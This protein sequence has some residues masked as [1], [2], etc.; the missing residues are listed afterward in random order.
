[1][2]CTVPKPRP[3][4]ALGSPPTRG[5][6]RPVLFALP[7]IPREVDGDREGGHVSLRSLSSD[8]RPGCPLPEIPV[9]TAPP[10]PLPLRTCA[11]GPARFRPGFARGGFVP[12]GIFLAIVASVKSYEH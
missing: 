6:S 2:R 4:G 5:G 9:K 1:M 10:L 12:K 7:P 11:G 8:Q 3:P